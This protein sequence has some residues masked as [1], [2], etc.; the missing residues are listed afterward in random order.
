MPLL[1]FSV[2]TTVWSSVSNELLLDYYN[3]GNDKFDNPKI[4]TMISI[5]LKMSWMLIC[6]VLFS[7]LGTPDVWK[8]RHSSWCHD[9]A[10]VAT[11]W[12]RQFAVRNLLVLDPQQPSCLFPAM[13]I[14]KSWRSSRSVNREDF[15]LSICFRMHKLV[16]HRSLQLCSYRQFFRHVQ[17]KS[18]FI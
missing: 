1:L 6:Y 4:F 11:G 3:F 18:E 10:C 13:W 14:C 12:W 7:F 8:W 2:D 16:I 15:S 17:R 5:L 9:V